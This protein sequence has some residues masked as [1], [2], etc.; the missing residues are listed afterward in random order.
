[1]TKYLDI[2]FHH[3]VG[4]ALI[5]LVLPLGLSALLIVLFPTAQAGSSLWVDNPNYL[6]V[7]ATQTS[8]WNQYLTPAQNA[9]D[10]LTAE[11]ASG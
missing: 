3:L 10:I 4:F 8:N 2:L 1:M 7:A 5:L 11:T 6:D 9:S